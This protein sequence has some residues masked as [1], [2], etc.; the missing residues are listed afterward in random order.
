[1]SKPRKKYWNMTTE[2]LAKATE[3]FDQEGV[4]DTFGPMTR[5]AEV[6]WRKA[7][8]KPARSR[9]SI[10]RSLKVVSLS[11]ETGLLKQ[12]DHLARKRGISRAKLVEEGL[13][14]LLGKNRRHDGR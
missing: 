4:A 9:S 13:R 5:Q 10:G 12:A 3:E 2:E 1:M 6:A 7:R 8:R 11:I 14:N